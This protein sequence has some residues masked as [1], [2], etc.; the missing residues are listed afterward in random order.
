M[1]IITLSALTLFRSNGWLLSICHCI[2]YSGSDLQAL[3]EEAAMMPIRELGANILTIKAN[4]V[5]QLVIIYLMYFI[6]CSFL[7]GKLSNC[8]CQETFLVSCRCNSLESSLGCGGCED[9]LFKFLPGSYF[10]RQFFFLHVF[11]RWL[12]DKIKHLLCILMRRNHLWCYILLC[13]S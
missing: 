11:Q 12:S 7:P 13:F 3:C 1:D 2:G 5:F 10:L 9:R 6:Y 4:Q 8:P